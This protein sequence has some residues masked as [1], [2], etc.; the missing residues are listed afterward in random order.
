MTTRGKCNLMR[1]R[2]SCQIGT[3]SWSAAT[4][5]LCDCTLMGKKPNIQTLC[6]D[7]NEEPV[8]LPKRGLGKSDGPRTFKK[9][10][11]LGTLEP[12]RFRTLGTF[13]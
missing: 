13:V 8:E 11:I 12:L 2:S 10:R 1:R 7:G 3:S 9:Y 4:K 5:T 6:V